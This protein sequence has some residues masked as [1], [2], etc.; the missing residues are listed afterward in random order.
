[1][2]PKVKLYI[3]IFVFLWQIFCI[4]NFSY[5]QNEVVVKP[6]KSTKTSAEEQ[7][8]LWEQK[9]MAAKARHMAMQDEKT[10]MKMIYD[11]E[12]TNKYYD[13]QRKS[14]LRKEFEAFLFKLKRKGIKIKL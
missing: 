12:L 14:K 13:K 9:Y 10:R 3:K 2:K 8:L 6:K 11:L 5:C 1:M 4:S 7:K